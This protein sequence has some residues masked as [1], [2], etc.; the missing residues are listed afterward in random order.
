MARH[1]RIVAY[2]TSPAV[3][4]PLQ[5]QSTVSRRADAF[6][7]ARSPASRSSS[8][9]RSARMPSAQPAAPRRALRARDRDPRLPLLGRRLARRRAGRV[10]P[11]GARTGRASPATPRCSS[12]A[13]RSGC[14][15]L[16]YYDDWLK[17]QRR[18][19]PLVGPGAA[20]VDEFDAS[21]VDRDA[22][23]RPAARAADRDRHRP[24]QLRRGPRD[25]AVGGRGRDLARARPDHRLR[26]AQRD[27]GVRDR[28]PDGRPRRTGR[29]G[30]SSACSG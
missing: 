12:S 17:R 14:M 9:S 20:A 7:S 15:S 25:R 24:A 18:A 26:A 4:E 11:R 22:L 5:G 6:C 30:A 1:R 23:A 27:R 29:A 19:T 3:R 8:A 28:R 21:L 13:S 2:C 16:V 10:A